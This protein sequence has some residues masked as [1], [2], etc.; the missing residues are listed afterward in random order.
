[1][2]LFQRIHQTFFSSPAQNVSLNQ[3]P[4][5]SDFSSISQF[6]SG[7]IELR[8]SS[9]IGIHSEQS[10]LRLESLES[11][12]VPTMTYYGGNLLTNVQVQPIF[13]G[14]NWA[15]NNNLS[16]E[17]TNFS[18]YLNYMVTSPFMDMLH[19]ANYNVGEG[20]FVKGEVYNVSLSSSSYLNDSTIQS[21][22]QSEISNGDLTAPTANTLYVVYVEPNIAVTQGGVDSIS[23]FAG[24][25]G[26]YAGTTASGN[27]ANIRYAVIT[28]PGGSTI[29]GQP[30]GNADYTGN[31]TTFQSMTMVSSHELAEAVTDPDVNYLTLGWYDNANN[32]EIGDIAVNTTYNNYI[33]GASPSNPY[34][35]LNGY[36]LQYMVDIND[37]LIFPA[38][39][40]ISGTTFT[41]NAGVQF[42]GQV[43]SASDITDLTNSAN[44]VASINWGDGTVSS[45]TI[46]VQG[47]GSY[48]IDGTH[49]YQGAGKYTVSVNLFD[50]TNSISNVTST[51]P[52]TISSD[53]SVSGVSF[54]ARAGQ[55]FS[56][57]VA[58]A[59]DPTQVSK[60][61]NLV[62]TIN[63]GDGTTTTGTVVDQGNGNF[64]IDGTHTYVTGGVYKVTVTLTDKT[65]S[66]VNVSE[67]TK[68]TITGLILSGV[69]FSATAGS[70][71]SG[72]VASASDPSLQ[73]QLSDL[74]AIIYWGDGTSS[75]AIIT[76]TG[77]D[78]FIISGSHTYKSI[79]ALPVTVSITDSAN[80]FNSQS[81]TTTV[82]IGSPLTLAGVGFTATTGANFSGQVGTLTDSSGYSSLSNLSAIIYWGDGTDS[83]GTITALGNNQYAINGS[84]T[85][86]ITGKVNV[87]INLVD[88][89]LGNGNLKNITQETV[90]TGLTLQGVGFSPIIS[91]SFSG[92]IATSTDPT[93]FTQLSNLVAVINWGDGVVTTATIIDQGND[94]FVIDGTHTYQN[95]GTYSVT[96]SIKDITNLN[97]N[98]SESTQIT[99]LSSA[100]TSSGN[101]SGGSG[102]G[103][104]TAGSGPT[105]SP[106]TITSSGSSTPSTYQSQYIW[107]AYLDTF[108][109]YAYAQQAY[110]SGKGSL[111]AFEYD[112]LALKV[113]ATAYQF[114]LQGDETDT[115]QY[116]TEAQQLSNLASQ[117]ELTNYQKTGNIQSAYAFIYS[118]VAV[119]A[120]QKVIAGL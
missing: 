29:N 82:T 119:Q 36:A 88:S 101:G 43:A 18:N 96:V 108:L 52:V 114:S 76:D 75:T 100:P 70:F 55:Q 58:T 32:G 112:S 38:A 41:T 40:T 103:G 78:N 118:Y 45:G 86:K 24:Y 15:S 20:S 5:F 89:A 115:I 73:T 74:T 84:H 105:S 81:E 46:V 6:F 56:G 65:D 26:A 120:E 68:E 83:L 66:Y 79:G 34:I 50:S 60:A 113:I 97:A 8:S 35:F 47:T 51:T 22:I 63:W 80:S 28:T 109:S 7:S 116:A 69:T 94:N 1:M 59:S 106:A 77:N 64:I 9:I 93:Q 61:A 3:S 111:I 23:Y 31:L 42:S 16:A 49:T 33:S 2:K 13:Y 107:P 117:V 90:D 95:A 72:Q 67:T 91:Q 12:I 102:S 25:H 21:A 99:V 104:S 37:N 92:A 110:A 54:N 98:L 39:L 11:R 53:L 44:L 87:Q 17:A 71:F 4:K 48:V 62:A 19:K 85:Y 30:N 10:I 57:E 27:S 14:S